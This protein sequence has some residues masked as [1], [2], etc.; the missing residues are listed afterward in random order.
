MIVMALIG[1]ICSFSTPFFAKGLPSAKLNAAARDVSSTI[2]H[3]RSLAQIKGEN[4]TVIIDTRGRQY[5]ISGRALK[6]VPEDIT[7]RV[8]EPVPAE[9]PD[10]KHSFLFYA[11][12]GQEAGSIVL[13][14]KDRSLRID[15]DPVAGSIT[16]KSIP[17]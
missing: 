10:G 14:N 16:I 6:R 3:A 12:G 7:I 8:I 2:R 13:G 15:T 4:Q 17:L 11:T 5:G 1:I 9:A